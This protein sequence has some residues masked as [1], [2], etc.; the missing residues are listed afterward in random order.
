MS[1]EERCRV[2]ETKAEWEACV[3]ENRLQFYIFSRL[4]AVIWDQEVLLVTDSNTQTQESSGIALFCR[5][6]ENAH[7]RNALIIAH[8]FIFGK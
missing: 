4:A 8:N 6:N 5:L 1:G 3:G 2:F 7:A